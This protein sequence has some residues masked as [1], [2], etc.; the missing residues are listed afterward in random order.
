MPVPRPAA[1]RTCTASGRTISLAADVRNSE[2]AG[3]VGVERPCPELVRSSD[4]ND[5][6]RPHDSDAVAE[7]ERLGLIVRHVHGGQAELVEEAGEIVE[8][9]VAKAPIEG[10]ERLVEQEEARL[11]CQRTG[12]SDA[13]LL[14]AG[15]RPDRATLEAGE[16]DE[17]EQ[18]GRTPAIASGGSPRIRRPKDTLPETSRCGKSA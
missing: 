12:E 17:R 18:L 13:L 15:E 2:E 11:G 16:P 6:P 14:S 7:R 10:S 8:Q 9:A 3:D 4:L 1:G 5:A